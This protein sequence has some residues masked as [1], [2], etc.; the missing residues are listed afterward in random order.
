MEINA[1][2]IFEDNWNAIRH[3]RYIK[4]KG[5]SRSSKTYSILQLFWLYALY[6]KNKKLAVFRDTK[7][8]CVDT[9]W[10]DML[11]AYPAMPGWNKVKINYT[12][13]VIYF[14]NGSAIYIEGTDDA[15]K[16][17]GYHSDVLWFNEPYN[18]SKPTFDQLDM[19]CA[20]F[21][22]LDLNPR[23]DHW[24]DA[25]ELQTSCC[26]IHSTFRQNPFCPPNQ[27]EKI[28]SYQN[29]AL[30]DVV[31][32]KI[33]SHK[34]AETYDVELNDRVIDTELLDNL[35][36]CR[37]NELTGTASE[38]DWNV[39]GLGLKAERPNR[40]FKWEAVPN[41]V[42]YNLDATTYTGVDWGKVDPWGILDAK[43]YDGGLYLHELNYKSENQYREEL[44]R[45]RQ[46]D[47]VLRNDEGIVKWR[48]NQLQIPYDREIICDTNRPLKI[49][50]LRKIG[51]EYAVEATKGSGS[52][53][54]GIDLLLNMKVYY[55]ESSTNLGYEQ[56]NYSYKTD[57]YSIVMEEAEDINNHLLD[58]ARYVAERMRQIGLISAV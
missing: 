19:R 56:E 2:V 28:L 5:S 39:Y 38:Y 47:A 6:N 42:F 29:I 36:R 24:S 26:V 14:P 57:R 22:I 21:V 20:D 12:K 58:P 7:K 40:V 52:I 31:T 43:Y 25:L 46:L 53:Q 18:I 51:Y 11:K 35:I 44:M 55:T 32:E 17:H 15:V 27:R 45:S 3:F 30:S 8:L 50:A 1:T 49:R 10:Q 23:G 48:F 4:N 33:L 13:S 54:D 37:Y 34:E 16:V 9:V 41:H